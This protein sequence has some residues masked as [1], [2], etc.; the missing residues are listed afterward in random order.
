MVKNRSITTLYCRKTSNIFFVLPQSHKKG[1]LDTSTEARDIINLMTRKA[2]LQEGSIY[3]VNTLHMEMSRI[4]EDEAGQ[5][6]SFT[7]VYSV[8]VVNCFW[9]SH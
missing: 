4:L 8:E 5:C 6:R 3:C 7:M 1:I 9:L 2:V